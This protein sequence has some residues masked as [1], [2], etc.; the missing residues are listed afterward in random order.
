MRKFLGLLLILF[1]S[2]GTVLSIPYKGAEKLALD[3]IA[4]KTNISKSTPKFKVNFV[5]NNNTYHLQ[6]VHVEL[7]IDLSVV[8]LI[9]YTSQF[10]YL[11][12][13]YDEKTGIADFII[14]EISKTGYT[15][16]TW[17]I[18]EFEF[19][20]I[21]TAP[22]GLNSIISINEVDFYTID[23]QQ[24][25]DFETK[26]YL[27]V[28]VSNHVPNV[29]LILLII[30]LSIFSI[31]AFTLLILFLK[32]RPTKKELLNI[33]ELDNVP[34]INRIGKL[35]KNERERRAAEL[36][37]R[38]N[39]KKEAVLKEKK[40]KILSILEVQKK[41][42]ERMIE[43]SFYRSKVSV[44]S[45]PIL[46]S[47]TRKTSKKTRVMPN[48]QGEM[49]PLDNMEEEVINEEINVQEEVE[50]KDTLDNI[51]TDNGGYES[52]SSHDKDDDEQE[53]NTE[54]DNE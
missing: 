2:L 27:I 48:Y 1:L 24:I 18:L 52:L 10:Q 17:N 30:F 19:E 9:S 28:K 21:S 53:D 8:S 4:T 50:K 26:K 31:G 49:D 37:K 34:I 32:T 6:N 46:N 15:E 29:L 39:H 38:Q 25:Y 16:K 54:K 35:S 47:V 5:V 41:K 13:N 23:A 44:T 36:K 45:V 22:S 3:M 11:L 43:A 12:F 7:E 40:A 42:N 14:P 20:V 51:S 33:V